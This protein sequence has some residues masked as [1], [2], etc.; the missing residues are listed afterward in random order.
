M[1]RFRMNLFGSLHVS[2]DFQVVSKKLKSKLFYSF[3][4]PKFIGLISVGKCGFKIQ[5]RMSA[6]MAF[7]EEEHAAIV[8]HKA[9]HSLPFFI[10]RDLALTQLLQVKAFYSLINEVVAHVIN[11]NRAPLSCMSSQS[12]LI[13]C[14][15]CSPEV[16]ISTRRLLNRSHIISLLALSNFKLLCY[17]LDNTYLYTI[18]LYYQTF[19]LN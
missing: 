1:I 17:F 9:M 11:S 4:I 2:N 6:R 8:V 14:F 3:L 12:L 10:R 16:N 19:S 5:D 7:N 15:S 13:V 18:L